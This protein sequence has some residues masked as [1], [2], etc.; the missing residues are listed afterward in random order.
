MDPLMKR[1][2]QAHLF[3]PS[4]ATSLQLRAVLVG[5]GLKGNTD[6]LKHILVRDTVL[7]LIC[8]YTLLSALSIPNYKTF[9][10]NS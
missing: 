8:W 9:W 5:C 2:G 10:F 6:C 4:A 7:Q 1:N 3:L